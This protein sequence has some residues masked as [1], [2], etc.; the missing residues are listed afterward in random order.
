MFTSKS[1]HLLRLFEHKN[2]PV[3]TQQTTSEANHFEL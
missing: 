2:V 1:S 3:G